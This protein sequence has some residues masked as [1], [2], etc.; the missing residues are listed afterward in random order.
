MSADS[1]R[2]GAIRWVN[3]WMKGDVELQ[4]FHEK[5]DDLELCYVDNMETLL[6]S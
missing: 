4:S 5:S 1:I 3:N 2:A 6:L